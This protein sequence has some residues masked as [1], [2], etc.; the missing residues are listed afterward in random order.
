VALAFVIG[1]RVVATI[2]L[3]LHLGSVQRQE[4]GQAN[5]TRLC[6]LDG[7]EVGKLFGNG[8]WGRG[9]RA[10][11]HIAWLKANRGKVKGG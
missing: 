5:N 1:M 4:K 9:S 10:D 6:P 3:F 8:A 7:L 2:P 11:S